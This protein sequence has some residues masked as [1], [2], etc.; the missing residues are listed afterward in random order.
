MLDRLT[1]DDIQGILSGRDAPVATRI[2]GLIDYANGTERSERVVRVDGSRTDSYIEDGSLARPFKTIQAAIDHAGAKASAIKPYVVEVAPG[3]YVENVVLKRYVRLVDVARFGPTGVTV[4]RSASG[5]TLTLP[6]FDSFVNGLWVETTS[7][8]PT[9]SAVRHVDD[10]LAAGTYETFAFNL[11]AKATGA[12][13]AISVE[14][15]PHGASLIAIYA[16]VDAGPGSDGVVADGAGFIW[17]LGGGGGD[18]ER[19][20]KIINGGFGMFG[21]SVG[22]NASE[23]SPTA[24]ALEVDGG[25]AVFT[26]ATIAATNGMM[27][28]NGAVVLAAS[29]SSFGGFSGIPVQTDPGTFFGIGNVVLDNPGSPP[30]A[31][32][33]LNGISLMLSNGEQ[34]VG[35]AGLGGPDLRPVN[36]PTGFR[37]FAQDMLP[38][39]G[40]GPGSWLTWNGAAWVDSTGAL[41]P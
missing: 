29:L 36:P 33:V 4:L 2:N 26:G 39:G 6:P 40:V 22:I 37:F 28:K 14:P 5:H 17:F 34:G 8:T 1:S 27:L 7:P 25:F 12:A 32:W 38:G 3:V 35:T 21:A 16:G 30:L 41:I 19:G 20:V 23:T 24:W 11:E 18:S 9:D 10:G 13:R 15:N 31:G